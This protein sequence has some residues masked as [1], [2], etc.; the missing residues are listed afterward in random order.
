MNE[1]RPYFEARGAWKK[2]KG[3]FH[4]VGPRKLANLSLMWEKMAGKR[5]VIILECN[6]RLPHEMV[7]RCGD[8]C[9]RPACK[10]Y[11]SNMSFSIGFLL[12]I[13]QSHA[14]SGRLGGGSY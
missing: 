9:E 13:D 3:D 2:V 8:M 10:H 5:Q 4:Y 11:S 6:G 7:K 14:M 12:I 1:D